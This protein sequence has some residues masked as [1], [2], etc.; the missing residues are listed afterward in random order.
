[1]PT[2]RLALA[3]ATPTTAVAAA[4]VEIDVEI[5]VDVEAE[6]SEAGLDVSLYLHGL[7]LFNW[8]NG[9]VIACATTAPR[10]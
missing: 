9:V 6:Q 8:W 2:T 3:L 10:T 5:E 7:L 1:M 4:E